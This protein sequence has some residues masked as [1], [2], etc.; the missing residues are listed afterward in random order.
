MNTHAALAPP[1]QQV[2]QVE[3]R[4]RSNSTKLNY[5]PDLDGLRGVAVAAILSIHTGLPGIPGAFVGLD[6]F[7]VISGFLITTLLFERIS[8][9]E[10]TFS[11][12]YLNRIR[13]LV[14]AA[15]LTISCTTLVGFFFLLPSDHEELALSGLYS[16]FSGANFF[17][18][19]ETVDYFKPEFQ[20]LAL[21][22]MWSLSL[23]EQFYMLW[24]VLLYGGMRL[25]KSKTLVWVTALL[26]LLSFGLSQM[27]LPHHARAS[28]YLLP[29]RAGEL[30]LG[31][32]LGLAFIVYG[33]KLQKRTGLAVGLGLLGVLLI[34]APAFYLSTSSSFPGFNALV[35]C[36]GAV[37]LIAA[38]AFGPNPVTWLLSTRV[39]VFLG[40]ISYSLYLWHWPVLSFLHYRGVK[41]SSLTII[42]FLSLSIF[43]GTLSF[44][45]VENRYRYPDTT[46]RFRYRSIAT[47][48]CIAVIIQI[49]VIVGEGFK[50]RFPFKTLSR[51]E[52][53]IERSRYWAELE[54]RLEAHNMAHYDKKGVLV[55]GNSH[56]KDLIYGLLENHYPAHITYFPI[57]HQ[58]VDLAAG[59]TTPEWAG[60]CAEQLNAAIR[61]P[62]LRSVEA[63]YLATD[64]R[65]VDAPELKNLL[66]RFR[67]QTSAPIFMFGPKMRFVRSVAFIV[68]DTR[69][70]GRLAPE[71]I[72]AHALEFQ[73]P[74]VKIFDAQLKEFINS[75]QLPPRV[76]YVS[77]VELQCGAQD[78]CPVLSNSGEYLY[79]DGNHF[80]RT[81]ARKFGERLL[82]RFPQGLFEEEKEAIYGLESKSDLKDPASKK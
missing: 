42:L 6:L 5:R 60:A 2:D 27:L 44:Y 41:L 47:L 61:A 24:P 32:L 64:W 36:F 80:T 16:L 38:P 82:A 75:G 13:R 7:F 17:F 14:P 12:F 43:L 30:L 70:G 1:R 51:R 79:F 28:Y 20:Y 31:A 8:R 48:F 52:L 9:N 56:G 53:M 62:E 15:S 58:C 21:L 72:N 45:Y 4:P 18:W 77:T 35:P 81:G 25:L 68:F 76:F 69:K 40:R 26:A 23:E 34:A 39:P 65:S 57:S 19:G 22:H 11:G 49:G 63:V 74:Q 46:G 71:A 78:E 73:S 50:D 66:E 59:A 3:S 37:L 33:H 67:E 10:F 54:D 55:M 29:S